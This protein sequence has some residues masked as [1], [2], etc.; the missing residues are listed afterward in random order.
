MQYS[1]NAL[2]IM[3][4]KTYKGIGRAWIVKNIKGHE[5]DQQVV[6]LLNR[7]LKG[8]QVSVDELKQRKL[9]CAQFLEKMSDFADGVVALGDDNFPSHRGNVKNSEKPVLLFYRGNIALLSSPHNI[10][11]I[12]VLSPDDYT[13]AKERLLVTKLVEKNACIV[14]GLAQGCDAIAHDQALN[15]QGKTVAI[16]PSPLSNIMPAVNK[17]LAERII[18]ADGLLISEY[19]DEPKTKMELNG[20]YQERDRLQALFSDAI[21]LA[22]SYAKNDLGN[23][24]GS[25]LAMGYALNYDIQ[26]AVM[27]DE[28]EDAD[29]PK[30]DLNRQL[31]NESA[32]NLLVITKDMTNLN[33]L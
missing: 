33:L 28:L 11:V 7:D 26:R 10:A 27:Y 5:D 12:G 2:N 14:S 24:S 25:R 15:C 32:N 18:A 19:Y 29:N 9:K 20:R 17:P 22:S 21:I 4:A 23:D 31:I 8:I 30:Y 3:I 6:N 16:L 1:N 13:E